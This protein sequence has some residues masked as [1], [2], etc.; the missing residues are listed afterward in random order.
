MSSDDYF[1][2][3]PAGD[4]DALAPSRYR[5]SSETSLKI[6]AAEEAKSPKNKSGGGSSLSAPTYFSDEANR[7]PP[8]PDFSKG[9]QCGHISS[10]IRFGLEFITRNGQTTYKAPIPPTSD[11]NEL[12]Y[13]SA[14]HQCGSMA[15]IRQ[16]CS[17]R[18]N[19]IATFLKSRHGLCVAPEVVRKFILQD[20][21]TADKDDEEDAAPDS[22]GS[23]GA[24]G[25]MDLVELTSALIIPNLLRLRRKHMD[26]T[27]LSGATSSPSVPN[28]TSD[29][30]LP[31]LDN[32]AMLKD[33]LAL[34][35]EDCTGDA[36]PKPLD[37]E[38]VRDLLNGYGEG[39]LA[40]D[41]QLVREMVRWPRSG[42]VL[43]R[44][45]SWETRR[46][47]SLHSWISVPLSKL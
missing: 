39:A 7:L 21:L 29:K 47:R 42:A 38:L 16:D 27:Q 28:A 46:S 19:E 12:E 35:L 11:I 33:I 17:I 41:R 30:V 45:C 22:D 24:G 15:E 26:K 4:E 13:I 25:V 31:L 43:P 44:K 36:T 3:N 10:L 37:E 6:S 40:Q 14:L 18:S 8:L 23:D 34:M 2:D 5:K 32:T 20:G 9:F 1:A